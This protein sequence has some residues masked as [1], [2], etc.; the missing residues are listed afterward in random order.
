[1][2]SAGKNIKSTEDALQKVQVEHFYHCIRNPKPEV[3][4]QLR[5]LRILQNIDRTSYVAQ[6]RQLPYVVCASFNP[7]YRRTENFAFTEYFMLDVDHITEKGLSLETLRKS[8][9]SDERVVLSFLSPSEDGLKILFRLKERCSDAGLYA[10]FYKTFVLAFS[11][12]YSL[13][14]VVDAK[15]SDVTRACFIS[16]DPNAYYNPNAVPV[17]MGAFV[18]PDNVFDF[19]ELKRQGEKEVSELPASLEKDD[20]PLSDP[21]EE[22]LA[23]IKQI[24]NPKAAKREAKKEV[25]VPEILNDVMTDLKTHVESTGTVVK[26]IRDINYGKQVMVQIGLRFAE[27]NI[28]F[29]KQGFRVVRSTKSGTDNELNEVFGQLV[30][31]FIMEYDQLRHE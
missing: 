26:S 21:G 12:Q 10:V 11:R 27:V 9:E 20:T 16:A 1:M 4:A 28:F 7:P 5:Q 18:N 30:E 6:K 24:L 29:G 25:I 2:I 15:T 3:A 22:T 17:D 8:V 19:F 31:T 23:R 14:Q 13:E